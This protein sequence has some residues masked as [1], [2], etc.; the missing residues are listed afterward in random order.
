MKLLLVGSKDFKAGDKVLT[1]RDAGKG[2]WVKFDRVV[3][4][5][6]DTEWWVTG[7]SWSYMH[8]SYSNY[9]FEVERG[10][11]FLEELVIFARDL[12]VGDIVTQTF[13]VAANDWFPLGLEKVVT[14]VKDGRAYY[15]NAPGRYDELNERYKMRVKRVGKPV[16]S[17]HWNGK[18]RCGKS[19]YVGF[20]QIEH[21]GPC[22][23]GL[24]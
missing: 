20:L 9:E 22:Q 12:Q 3:S 14:S 18:C 16:K 5:V 19:T 2:A 17:G 4:K 15:N 7:V 10:S 21:D 24:A 8:G 23:M 1:Y 11:D 6:S 13:S